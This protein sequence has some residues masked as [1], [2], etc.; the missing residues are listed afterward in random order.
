MRK[1][2]YIE[3]PLLH[4]YVRTVQWISMKNEQPDYVQKFLPYPFSML[5]FHFQ[6]AP[7]YSLD[8][9]QYVQLPRAYFNIGY[10]SE[11]EIFMKFG[12]NVDSIVILLNP[13]SICSL[14]NISL[15]E[16]NQALFI[17]A[18][19]ALNERKEIIDELF[20]TELT[21]SSLTD[22]LTR[23]LMPHSFQFDYKVEICRKSIGLIYS[24]GANVSLKQVAEECCVS[25]R[26]LERY[27]ICFLGISPARYCQLVRLQKILAG[28]EQSGPSPACKRDISRSL[29]FDQSHLIKSF[30]KI[31]GETPGSIEKSRKSG[32]F[33]MEVQLYKGM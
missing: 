13:V 31:T 17:P 9:L 22:C 1:I 15:K 2:E 20:S 21:V 29:Y 23:L 7:S 18:E 33:D 8:G 25:L 4:S 32:L 11:R 30:K 19:E 3:L 14:F 5:S 26:T 16:Y 24:Q 12:E 10:Y 27:F 28:F 6:S